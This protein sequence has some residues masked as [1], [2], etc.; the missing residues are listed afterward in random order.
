MKISPEKDEVICLS[1]NPSQCMLHMSSN[2]LQQVEKFKCF[3]VV[4][5]SNEM[6]IKETGW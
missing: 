4:S 1:R 6:R 5:T 2:T 3:G